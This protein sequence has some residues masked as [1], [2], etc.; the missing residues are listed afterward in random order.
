M[1]MLP[2]VRMQP[3]Y[4]GQMG[5]S[6]SDV[7]RGLRWEPQG[8]VLFVDENHPNTSGAADGTDP[9]NPLNSIQ[10]AVD[11]LVSFSTSMSTSLEG[12]VIVVA[13]E[14]TPQESVI[15]SPS[16]PKNCA[17]IGA[18]SGMNSP[19]WT[20]ATATGTALTIRQEGW[21]VEGFL[22]R[23]GA[24]GTSVQLD[25]VPGSDYV[26][27]RCVIRNNH[28]DGLWQGQYAIALNGAPY[29]TWITGNQFR[30]YRR[31]DD[32]AFA[33]ITIDS[34]EAN[35]YMNVI[36]DNMFWENENHIGSLGDNKSFNLSLFQGNVFHEGVLI[37]AT[38]MLDLRGGSQG[39]NIVV[40]NTFCGDYSNTGGYYA[41]AG[42]PGNWVGNIAEDV[43]EAEVGDNGITVDAPAA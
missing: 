35:A 10:T 31:D 32:S 34:S 43:A 3:W 9:E 19:A 7:Q 1:S 8:I 41:N 38:L 30:E 33:I 17:I 23:A 37:T 21:V 11:R 16:A 40:G 39:K 15:V 36:R 24:G 2:Q 12:S 6:G 42:S 5:V 14:S 22:F 13:D 4:S 18:G 29:D 26:G 25:W 20:A 27:N 28:F